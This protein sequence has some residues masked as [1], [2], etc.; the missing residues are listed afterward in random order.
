MLFDFNAFIWE[1]RENPEKKEIIEKYEKAFWK[2]SWW[3]KDQNRYTNYLINFK[4]QSYKVPEELENDFDRDL[5]QQL[6]LGSFS[7]DYEL[8]KENWE[9]KPELY[10]AVKSWDQSIVK[11]VSE[12]RS[13]QI[14]RLY[15]I[16]IEEQLNLEILRSDNDDPEWNEKKAIDQERIMRQK[17]RQAILDTAWMAEEAAKTK[18]EQE[19]S[20]DE[21]MWKL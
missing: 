21:L 6:V 4:P 18:E 15:E 5:L 10:I 11:K 17:R 16:Y 7:S 3:L 13:F 8:K 14:Q 2:I 12:L 19:K 1:L 9:N 20:L